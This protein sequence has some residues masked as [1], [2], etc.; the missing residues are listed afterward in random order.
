MREA[1]FLGLLLLHLLLWAAPV[2]SPGPEWEVP[3]VWAQEGAPAQL[4]CSPAVPPQDLSLLRRGKVIWQHQPDSVPPAA[5]QRYTVLRVEH[6][7]L[8][9]GRLPLQPRVRL[10]ERGLQRG[11][12]SLWLRPAQRADAG[13]YSAVVSLGGRH[14]NCRLRLRVGQASSLE[15]PA[16]LTIYAE[17]DSRVELPC[18][19]P[20]GGGSSPFL[21]AKWTPPGGRP[22]LQV[23]RDNGNFALELEAVSQAQAGTY[24]CQIHLQGQLL[25]AT[26]TLAVITVTPTLAAG[27]LG[28]LLCEVTPATGH[29]RFVWSSLHGPVRWRIPGPWLEVPEARLLEPWQCQLYQEEKL[30]G[31]AVYTPEP[32]RPGAQHAGRTPDV[33]RNPLSASVILGALSLLLLLT[34]AFGIL[35]RRQWRPRRFSALEHGAP[36]PHA[37]SKTE[38]LEPE[39]LQPEPEPEPELGLEPEPSP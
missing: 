20:P 32:S 13:K 7:G 9:S 16:P 17:A 33:L 30:L 29:E 6:G 10:E 24:I 5:P 39:E 34:V 23:A 36:P 38:E 28:K 31:A 22:D 26:V 2:V 19:L 3:V 18:H 25:S 15:P 14:F 12:F 37:Q 1:P 21:T 8:R 35:W 11:D 4:P 27:S